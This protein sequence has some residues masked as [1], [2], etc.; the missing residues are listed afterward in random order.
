MQLTK[1]FLQ[2]RPSKHFRDIQKAVY[3]KFLVR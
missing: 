1:G 2:A 3:A